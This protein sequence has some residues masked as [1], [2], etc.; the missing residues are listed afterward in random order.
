MISANL[1][2]ALCGV[3]FFRKKAFYKNSIHITHRNKEGGI[4]VA[5]LDDRIKEIAKGYGA[6]TGRPPGWETYITLSDYAVLREMALKEVGA[7]CT[8]QPQPAM[9][10]TVTGALEHIPGHA[11]NN[12]PEQPQPAVTN[13]KPVRQPKP[14]KSETGSKSADTVKPQAQKSE[15]SE[16]A[17]L[18]ALGEG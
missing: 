17:L 8:A 1:K 15:D 16:L 9:G 3:F 13:I 14:A 18:L 12:G 4:P 7:P 10:N 2:D 5:V 6:L 11:Q